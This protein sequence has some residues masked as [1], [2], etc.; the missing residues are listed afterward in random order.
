MRL[1]SID[2]I[3][4]SP[5]YGIGTVY[6]DCADNQPRNE[7]LRWTREWMMAAHRLL[8][9]HGSFFLNISGKPSDP[10]IPLEVA[11]VAREFF[12]L[13]NTFHW[14]KSIAIGEV[15][16]GHYK[17]INSPRF[18]NDCCE[19]VFHF[20]HQGDVPIQR[21]AIGV[22]YTD[23]SNLKRWSSSQENP[24]H[25][26]GNCWY[27]PYTTRQTKNLHPA[28]FPIELPLNCLKLHGVPESD[29]ERSNFTC[30]D[31]FCGTG[32]TML[33][34]TRLGISG[35]GFD[36]SHSYLE[37]AVNRIRRDTGEWPEVVDYG[38]TG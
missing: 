3:V 24:L 12:Q 38:A 23:P 37:E 28:E 32:A 30:L 35:T 10:W 17:P 4:T 11:M 2:A 18:V 29:I 31:P 22:P 33:A 9:P 7:Y 20:T 27:L 36:L 16:F 34:C 8:K 5:P 19:Y 15:T 21:K 6:S 14:V 26:R 1:E 13:Q 25:C